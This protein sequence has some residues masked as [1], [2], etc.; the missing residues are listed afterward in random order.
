VALLA[1]LKQLPEEQRDAIV[2]HY[3]VDLPLEEIALRQGVP[4]GT[5]KSRLSRGR[6]ALAHR[7]DISEEIPIPT[8]VL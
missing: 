7:L 5:V 4:L 3:L 6:R 1:G 8:C 2:L